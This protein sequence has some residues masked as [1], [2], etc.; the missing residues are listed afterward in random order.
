MSEYWILATILLPFIGG[1]MTPLLPFKNRKMM[2]WYLE[3]VM[4]TTS[5]I[6]WKLLLNGT[7]EVFHIIHFVEDLSISFKIDGMSMIF[8]GLVSVLWPLAVL[9]SFEYM[10]K[11]E[12]EKIFFMFYS[13][14]YGIT[15]GIAFASDLLSMYFFYELLTL[16][17]VP[18]VL[19]TLKR[20]AVLASRKYLYYSIGGAAFAMIGLVFVIIYGV[21]CEFQMGGVLNM[22]L[23]GDKKNLLLWIYL[24]AFM[25][26]GVKA[27]MWPMGSWL[28]DAGVAPTP[29]TALLHAV[30]VVKAGVFAM[31]RLTYYSFG[32]SFLRGTWVQNVVMGFA[33]FTIVYGC[34]MAVKETHFKRRLAWST[35]S[36]LSYVIFGITIMTPLGLA[37]ALCHLVCHA[38]MKIN[39]FF[40]AGAFMQRT[41]RSYVYEMDGVGRKMPVVF[42]CFTVSALGLMGVPGLAGF[43]SKWNLAS[44]AVESMNVQAYFGI[45]CLLVSALLTAIYMMSTVIHAFF[46]G[47]DF[48]YGTLAGV[49]DPGWK[50]CVPLLLFSISIVAF[51]FL[52]GPFVEF[53]RE[54]AVG[55]Y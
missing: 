28:P 55:V 50:M 21:T 53:L 36:N 23:I 45:G 30:A 19:H 4:L 34:S 14:T 54:V 49:M 1:I 33:M 15:L 9:Y 46:P 41:G 3:A 18:L 43:I 5:A 11:E 16:S 27:A 26:F 31:I 35:V 22:A 48:D 37:G 24:L 2:M 51:G 25:G 52:S 7:T 42:G 17:T 20:E 38:V 29:V 32:T 39:A 8:A 13:T 44:A 12:R 6:V 10:E 47:K 40:C